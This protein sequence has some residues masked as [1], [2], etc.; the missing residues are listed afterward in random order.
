[1]G[2]SVPGI[3]FAAGRVPD[4]QDTGLLAA[5]QAGALALAA[6]PAGDWHHPGYQPP[7]GTPL[8]LKLCQCKPSCAK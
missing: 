4:P 3:E 6:P 7:A 2:C 8:P 5:S 1:M